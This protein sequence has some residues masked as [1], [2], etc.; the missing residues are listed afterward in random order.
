VT[1]YYLSIDGKFLGSTSTVPA[2]DQTTTLEI[3][4]TD[5]QTLGHIWNRPDLSAPNEPPA[6]TNNTLPH[7]PP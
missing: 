3:V 2:S 1:T 6:D 5:V 7:S 4:P